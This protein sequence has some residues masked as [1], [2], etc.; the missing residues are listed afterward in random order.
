MASAQE[1]ARLAQIN[2]V[3]DYILVRG[4]GRIIAQNMEN[5]ASLGQ[6]IATSGSQC[7]TLAA[8]M[9]GNRYIHLC[10]ERESGNDLLVF[11]LGR[12]YLGIVKH[13]E[14]ER[15]EVIDNIIYFL[16]NLS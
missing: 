9:G 12:L 10:L 2:G 16:K 13:A 7:D 3:A 4:D 5:D 6:L 11:S 15:Q 14:S 8:D 1:F